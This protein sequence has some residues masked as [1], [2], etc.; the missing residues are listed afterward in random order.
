MHN[1]SV[2]MNKLLNEK[3]YTTT[4][5]NGLKVYICKKEGF[6][7][8]IGMFGT[9]YGSVDNEFIDI[10][11]NERVKVPDGVAHFL[12]HKLFEQEGANAL[13]LFSKIGVSANA[14]TSFD[15]TVYFFETIERFEES[16]GLLIKLVKSPYF[17]D[18]N[19]K[20][21]QG[22]IGQEISMYEDDSNYVAY[23]NALSAMY[24]NNPVKIDIAGTIESISKINKEILYTCYNTFYNPSNMFMVIIGDVDIEKT[25]E[26]IEKNIKIYE[27]NYDNNIT[28]VKIQKFT[29]DEPSQIHKSDIEKKMEVYM[30]ELCI[31]YK[32]DIVHKKDSLK[33]E[34]ISS[35]ISDMFFSKMTSFFKEGY[36]KGILSEPVNF[37]CENSKTFSHII[38]SGYSTKIDELKDS[39]IKYVEKIKNEKLDKELFEL[40]KRKKIG[41]RILQSD[42]ISTSYRR[43]IGSILSENDIYEDVDILNEIT[44][45]D[46][47]EFLL[48]IDESKRVVSTIREK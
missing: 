11:T 34:I 33:R 38:I 9:I 35:I 3:T 25:L 8:K 5:K 15:H 4:L 19:V 27:K 6:K 47:K 43:I 2:L 31:G 46:V 18:E 37:D 24:K 13:D 17:T 28:S 16:L 32:L 26:T 22:I 7:K 39:I 40:I 1:I 14:Y 45:E 42:N 10:K 23:F 41:N 30:P 29:H 44:L 20:K 12:E 36:D 48:Q 21:E